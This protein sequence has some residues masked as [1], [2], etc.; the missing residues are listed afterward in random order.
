MHLFGSGYFFSFPLPLLS[1]LSPECHENIGGQPR[2][3]LP[4]N[5]PTLCKGRK[6]ERKESVTSQAQIASRSQWK[7]GDPKEPPLPRFWFLGFFFCSQNMACG[8]KAGT[9]AIKQSASE[10]GFH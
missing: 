1:L 2:L 6:P 5:S 7:K 3:I 9:L 4:E 10:I 8:Q